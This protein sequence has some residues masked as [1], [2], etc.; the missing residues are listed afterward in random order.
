M[1]KRKK[2]ADVQVYV[3]ENRFRHVDQMERWRQEYEHYQAVEKKLASVSNFVFE[4]FDYEPLLVRVKW[5]D[6]PIPN[7]EYLLEENRLAAESKFFVPIALRILLLIVMIFIFFI[8]SKVIVLWTA[9]TIAVATGASLY[10]T[11]IQRRATIDSV[12]AKTKAEIE[13]LIDFARQKN[14]QAR[15]EHELKEDQRIEYITNL[16]KN[17]TSAIVLRLDNEMGRMDF[18]FPLE[19]DIDIYENIPLIK[20][21]LPPKSIIPTQISNLSSS[22][23]LTYEEKEIRNVNK[24]YL[25]LCS[26]ILVRIAA[27]VYE[28]IPGFDRGYVWGLRREHSQNECFFAAKIDREK[29][30]YA[31]QATNGIAALHRLETQF[32]TNS[33]FDL[34]PFELSVPD[35][36]QDVPPQLIRNLHIKILK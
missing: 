25:E 20:V 6:C 12:M 33:I 31:C 4:P 18:P 19:I 14:E 32:D 3:E 5:K 23:R 26:A 16:L 10:S 22:G 34:Q 28:N 8:S 9:S 2:R 29:V 11:I 35:E 21:W 24:Q 17:E 7:F 1:N 30:I 27:K 13:Q 15:H 36:W